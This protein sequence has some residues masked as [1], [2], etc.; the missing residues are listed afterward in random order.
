MATTKTK[1]G[2][3][4]T[5]FVDELT[6]KANRDGTRAFNTENLIGTI[7]H[8]GVGIAGGF[9]LR[10]AIKGKDSKGLLTRSKDSDVSSGN[11]MT[12]AN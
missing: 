12:N 5:G 2:T 10:K 7:L 6:M 11:S 3:F 9:G 4:K 1:V 8:F